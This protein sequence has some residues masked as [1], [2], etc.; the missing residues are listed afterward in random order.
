VHFL[1]LGVD[2][3]EFGAHLDTDLVA[4]LHEAH[5]TYMDRW[6]DVL[7]AGAGAHARR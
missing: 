5:Q 4:S 2:G 3:P 6:A 1:V 7:V